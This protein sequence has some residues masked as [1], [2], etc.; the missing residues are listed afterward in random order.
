MK[1]TFEPKKKST[2][3]S[4]SLPPFPTLPT[5]ELLHLLYAG[6]GLECQV[7][8]AVVS[9]GVLLCLASSPEDPLG[10]EGGIGASIDIDPVRVPLNLVVAI[11]SVDSIVTGCLSLSASSSLPQTVVVL[12]ADSL[13]PQSGLA[14]SSSRHSH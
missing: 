1:R 13:P 3:T 4:L 7:L 8:G 12:S 14:V 10:V 11:A 2:H 9:S 6:S 5:L